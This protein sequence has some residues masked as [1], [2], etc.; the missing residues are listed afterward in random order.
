MAT[1]SGSQA[2]SGKKLQRNGNYAPFL[3][4]KPLAS[5]AL[6]IHQPCLDFFIA[7]MAFMGCSVGLFLDLELAEGWAAGG[8][9]PGQSSTGMVWPLLLSWTL[10]WQPWS[11]KLE[12]H[13]CWHLWH[14]A[15]WN[16]F[17]IHTQLVQPS[18]LQWMAML[19]PSNGQSSSVAVVSMVWVASFLA[20]MAWAAGVQGGLEAG[21]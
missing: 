3:L 17:Q 4:W 9:P 16:V 10:S 8:R 5:M 6:W 11:T 21:A 12:S 2:Q 15:N 20:A 1:C 19:W 14:L 13:G 7:F 18:P